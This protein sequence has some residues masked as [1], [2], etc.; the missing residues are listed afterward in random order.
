VRPVTE[1]NVEAVRRL[2]ERFEADGIDGALETMDEDIVIE[3]PPDLS[4]EPDDYRGHEGARRYFDGFT[5]MIDDVRY[6]AIGLTPVDDSVIAH[7]RLS[8]RGASSG[9]AV[10]LEAF[11]VHELANG[12]IVRIRPYAS[13]DDA[14]AA[15]G[16]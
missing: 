4:A 10:D 9:L 11:V 13:M 1:A 7:I 8:G 16:A 3:I 5:G 15:V 2:F 12:R 6:E 14:K